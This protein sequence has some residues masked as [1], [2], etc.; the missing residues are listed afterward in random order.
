MTDS[1]EPEGFE[2]DFDPLFAD[3]TAIDQND[4]DDNNPYDTVDF[5]TMRNM[6]QDFGHEAVY[7]PERQGDATRAL[8]ELIDHNPARRP[9]LLGIIEAC[10]GGMATSELEGRIERM[11]SANRSVYA[12]MTLCRMLER[13]GALELSMPEPSTAAEDVEAGV[14]F[15]QITE[16]IDPVWLSTEEAL[17]VAQSFREGALFD[18]IVLNRDAQYL[19]VYRAIMGAV[20]QAPR[21]KQWIEELTDTFEIVKHPRRFGGHF[22]DMLEKTDALAWNGEAWQLTELGKRMLARMNA[23]GN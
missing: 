16:T 5:P 8:L 21:S 18:D 1:L 11:Q 9:V 22:I 2:G 20:A 3:D 19:E 7:T 17:A 10:E 12:P 14:E 23:K 4:M 15:L 6:P 13:A